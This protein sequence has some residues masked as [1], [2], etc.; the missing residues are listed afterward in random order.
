MAVR[1]PPVGGLAPPPGIGPFGPPPD[2]PPPPPGIG[3]GIGPGVWQG[4]GFGTPGVSIGGSSG[5]D[6]SAGTIGLGNSS[7][8]TAVDDGPAA[9][10]RQI[11]ATIEEQ[12]TR[13]IEQARHDTESKVKMELKSLRDSMIVLD[14]QLDSMLAQLDAIEPQ[15]QEMPPLQSEIVAQLLSKIEQRWGQ[16]I[17][18]LKQEL[19][20]TILAHNHN[21]DLIKQQKDTIDMLRSRSLKVQSTN[22]KT[23]DLQT[24]LAALD[25]RLKQQNKQR[26]LEP[27]FER[28]AI[29]E[30][31]VATAAQS[32]AWRYPG[33]SPVPTGIPPAVMMGMGAGMM[34]GKGVGGKGGFPGFGAADGGLTAMGS[35]TGA[36][37]AQTAPSKAGDRAAYKCP[38]DE[39]VQARLSKVTHS[40]E[41]ALAAEETS[42]SEVSTGA[43]GV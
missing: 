20:Q 24:Q 10:H 6:L 43:N 3:S 32:A 15:E 30:Q 14:Q 12:V 2:M 27:F 18:T 34:P 33:M 38:T 37:G 8:S 29:L 36:A 39:E 42:K 13:M 23:S 40:A 25:A 16:E 5:G 35:G 11:S 41:E 17:R 28:L 26:K 7:M 22:V 31:K 9:R 4:T 19:H 1:P 21:A